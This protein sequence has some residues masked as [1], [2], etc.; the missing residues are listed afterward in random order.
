MA[1]G[2]PIINTNFGH[3]VPRRLKP[4][5]IANE[6]DIRAAEQQFD[7]ASLI[8]SSTLGTPSAMNEHAKPPFPPQH[9]AR[10][11]R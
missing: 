8:V 7:G 5:Q 4:N 1:P 11:S 9:P 3:R 6:N 2:P 10:P